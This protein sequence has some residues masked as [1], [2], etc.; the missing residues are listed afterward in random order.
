M[1][2]Y[3]KII[4]L[5]GMLV[6]CLL[7]TGC[8]QG[9]DNT[10]QTG[11]V[12]TPDH[13]ATLPPSQQGVVYPDS[14]DDGIP[15][16]EQPDLTP[17]LPEI[18]SDGWTS[19]LES[20]TPLPPNVTPTP[21]YANTIEAVSPAPATP[22]P[23]E[24]PTPTPKSIQRGFT[25]SDAVRDIQR[26]LKELGY[27]KG[28][29]DGDFGPATEKAVIAFQSSTVPRPPLPKIPAPAEKPPRLQPHPKLPRTPT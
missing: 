10:K 28:S 22:T 8:Q 14:S 9:S 4:I 5:A 15:D 13:F 2:N 27:Y 21:A 1:R 16:E 26:R 11:S 3:K 12:I 6:L 23:T 17:G 18:D 19:L 29:A 7:L 24:G 25:A 20:S